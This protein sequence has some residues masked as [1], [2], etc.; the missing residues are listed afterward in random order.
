MSDCYRSY[1]DPGIFILLFLNYMPFAYDCKNDYG[2]TS[3]EEGD[4]LPPS[5]VYV[6]GIINKR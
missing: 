3:F 2:G 1:H 5:V 4:R 6:W